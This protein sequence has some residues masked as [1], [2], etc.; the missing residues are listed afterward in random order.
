MDNHKKDVANNIIALAGMRA[1]D[2]PQQLDSEIF[3]SYFR[4]TLAPAFKAEYGFSIRYGSF[5]SIVLQASKAL[6]LP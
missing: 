2:D 5:K 1:K 3:K 4:K 6:D